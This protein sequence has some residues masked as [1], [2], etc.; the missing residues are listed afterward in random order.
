MFR[1]IISAIAFAGIL[2][3]AHPVLAD[4]GATS[5]SDH[6]QGAVTATQQPASTASAPS[7]PDV[8]APA[9]VRPGKAPVGFGWG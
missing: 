3:M 4:P 8:T 1:S 9:D 7:S 2:A 5:A 6:A